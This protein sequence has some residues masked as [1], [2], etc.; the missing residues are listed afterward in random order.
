MKLRNL[1]CCVCGDYAGKWQQHSNR[2]TG[3]GICTRCVEWL[4]TPRKNTDLPRESE[5]NIHDYYGIEGK[6]WGTVSNPA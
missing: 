5:E 2:D 1:T 6:N 3:F 4:R